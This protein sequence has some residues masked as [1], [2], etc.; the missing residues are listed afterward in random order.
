[1]LLQ[2]GLLTGMG[3]EYSNMISTLESEWKEG[4]TNLAGSILRLIRFSDIQKE[5]AKTP[6][7]APS[8]VLLTASPSNPVSHRAPVGTC[9]NQECIDKGVTAHFT[10]RCFLKYPELRT[11]Y[12]LRSMRPKGSRTNLRKDTAPAQSTSSS[13]NLETPVRES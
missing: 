7:K 6:N 3:D 8:N 12:S 9:T 5:D 13:T 10:D 1:M 2:A 4:E 11:R